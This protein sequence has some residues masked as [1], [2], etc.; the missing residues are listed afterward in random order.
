VTVS[1]SRRILLHGF[2]QLLSFKS[3]R[4]IWK[5]VLKIQNLGEQFDVKTPMERQKL[6]FFRENNRS[7]EERICS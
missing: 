3:E 1:F 5:I 4:D 2:S 7:A 6:A